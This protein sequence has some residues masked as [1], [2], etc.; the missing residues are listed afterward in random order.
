MEK[1]KQFLYKYLPLWIVL[2]VG[3]LCLI[4]ILCGTK[5]ESGYV[6]LNGQDATISEETKEWIEQA[7]KEYK[8]TIVYS[9]ESIPAL[10]GDGT[11]I[12]VP[13]VES[14]DDPLVEESKSEAGRG[15][16]IYAPTGS[17]D[18]FKNYTI[19]KC[20]DLDGYFGAQCVDLHNLFQLNYTKDQ[21]WLNLCGT[22]A[23]RGIWQCKEANAG[24]EYDLI[25]N[26][27][28]IKTGDWVITNGGE[29]G[30][31]CQ[32]AGPYNNGYVACLGENQGGAACPGGGAA[33][34]IINLSMGTFLG[35]FRPKTYEEPQPTP[36][37]PEP[38][39]KITYSYVPGDTFGNV[40]IKLGLDEGNLWGNAGT[41]KYYTKQLI[42]QG[43]LTEYGYVRLG[44]PFTLTRK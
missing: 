17:F 16:Y 3:L 20:W 4:F 29:W 41:V 38:G 15:S 30:H 2:G 25:Y 24:S 28:E 33:T 42:E 19:G 31:T 35:A 9:T 26:A 1:A 12:D 36:P 5:T 32:A 22:G 13:T 27:S 18:E 14:I 21:R 11:T 23:A 39:D 7:Q 8:A 37:T 10:L 6:T 34:N 43:A 40:L 44:F